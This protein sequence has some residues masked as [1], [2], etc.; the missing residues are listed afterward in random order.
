LAD[1]AAFSEAAQAQAQALRLVLPE[2]ARKRYGGAGQTSGNK[3]ANERKQNSKRAEAEQ[4]TSG[5]GTSAPPAETEK[6]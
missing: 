3:T 1:G 6:A 5:S 2:G 4:Q